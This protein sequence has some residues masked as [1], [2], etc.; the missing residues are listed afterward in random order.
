MKH[1]FAV[2]ALA[3]LTLLSA[4]GGGGGSSSGGSSGSGGAGGSSTPTISVV[5]SAT[6]GSA[7][8]QEGVAATVTFT[9]TAAS[10]AITTP[11]VAD[12][13]Y[14][15]T[16]FASV[17]A[18]AGSAGVYTVTATTVAGLAPGSYTSPITFRLCEDA[19]CSVVYTTS[20]VTYTTTLTVK[21]ADWATYQGNSA[22]TGFVDVTLDASKF[23]K[24]WGWTLPAA[25][26]YATAINSVATGNGD[27]FVAKDDYNGNGYV[28]ALNETDGSVV[29]T[30]NL[31]NAVSESPP[32]Y[33]NGR[34]YVTVLTSGNGGN[35]LQLDAK[36]GAVLNRFAFYGAG[37]VL[38]APVV[39]NNQ[40]ITP[41][42]SQDPKQILAV[43][44]IAVINSF[45]LD[46]SNSAM[47]AGASGG[48]RTSQAVAADATGLYY[49]STPSWERYTDYMDVFDAS[50][51]TLKASI[52]DTYAPSQPPSIGGSTVDD[53]YYGAPVIADAKTVLSYSG[54]DYSGVPLSSAEPLNSRA[55]VSFGRSANT[56][57]WK[58]AA[59]YLTT[60]AVAKGVVYLARNG[61]AVLDALDVSTGAVLW[62]WS[63]PAGDTAFHRNV[64]V[65]NNLVFVSTDKAV[66][67]IDL[68][69][70]QKVWSYAAAGQLAISSNLVLYIATGAT[71]SDGGLVAIRLQ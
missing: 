32:A 44:Y 47:Q 31:G 40:L 11:I 13:A 43:F 21:P 64:V 35:T 54:A 58:S 1:W 39:A 55:L 33:A 2:A 10:S 57:G 29:W 25:G 20:T 16:V 50:N 12:L 41:F 4:C 27:V 30:A 26:T 63:A 36:T 34:V 70:H 56:L 60:P 8:A 48:S 5:A 42:I 62:S 67:A 65:V 59:S 9:V 51:L 46:G 68:T 37:N 71:A 7:S 23:A 17:T 49:Y 15:K 66:Y 18:V 38:S 14:D 19:G 6:S 45:A 69:T 28:Y 52:S 3:A 24:A 22:H 61:P 53:G